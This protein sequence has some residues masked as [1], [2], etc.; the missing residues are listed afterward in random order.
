M[1]G[2]A[3]AWR[4]KICGY[5]SHM[6]CF[7]AIGIEHGN[8]PGDAAG[9]ENYLPMTS[10]NVAALRRKA[11]LQGV[12]LGD[13]I[14]RDAERLA[15]TDKGD[16]FDALSYS[17]HEIIQNVAEHS[18]TPD[19]RCCLQHWPTKPRVHL[20]LLDCGIGI[21]RSLE[22]NP[23][24]RIETD[25]AALRLALRPGISG[26]MYEGVA[27]DENTGRKTQDMGCA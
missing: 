25:L 3:L 8:R 17:L 10:M 15:R 18:E 7:P 24:M 5:Q 19:V 14:Q 13:V 2:A 11:Y 16:I 4:A 9:G 1:L 23:H 6:G 21:R 26:K 12:Q 27:R 22:R 20:A